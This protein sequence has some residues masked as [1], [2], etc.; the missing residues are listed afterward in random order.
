MHGNRRLTEEEV[1]ALLIK[2]AGEKKAEPVR[3]MQDDEL[4]GVAGGQGSYIIS[5][6]NGTKITGYCLHSETNDS[7]VKEALHNETVCQYGKVAGA[8]SCHY[9]C[10]YLVVMGRISL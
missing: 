3:V 10:P 9:D 6:A 7:D 4:D 8:T 5:D 1:A 2:R